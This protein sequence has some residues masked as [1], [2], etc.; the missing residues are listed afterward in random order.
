MPD[1][2]DIQSV[3]ID[4][5]HMRNQ[6]ADATKKAQHLAA[7]FV[8]QLTAAGIPVRDAGELLGVSPQRI[9]QLAN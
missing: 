4:L 9:S 8:T 7:E 5:V 1:V 2:G 3:A 6:A